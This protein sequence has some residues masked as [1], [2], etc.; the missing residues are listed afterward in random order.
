M[1]AASATSVWLIR[2]KIRRARIFCPTC[3]STAVGPLGL[4]DVFAMQ[5]TSLDLSKPLELHG[6]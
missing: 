3:V 6:F 1:S 4:N 5:I 2:K